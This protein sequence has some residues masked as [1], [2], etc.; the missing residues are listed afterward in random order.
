MFSYCFWETSYFVERYFPPW[1]VT[2]EVFVEWKLT[3]S[4]SQ[5]LFAILNIYIHRLLI[6]YIF[7]SISILL[8]NKQLYIV[9]FFSFRMWSTNN[10]LCTTSLRDPF[11]SFKALHH[12]LPLSLAL[13]LFSGTQ[14]CCQT[15][16][17][18]VIFHHLSCGMSMCVSIYEHILLVHVLKIYFFLIL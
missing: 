6:V 13:S 8:A 11:P 5:C 16:W 12:E 4:L 14:L 3:L 7:P 1:S 10:F 2:V 18:L 15:A 9:W 17:M